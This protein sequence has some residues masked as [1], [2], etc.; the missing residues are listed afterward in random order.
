MEEHDGLIA[1]VDIARIHGRSSGNVRRSMRSLG[2]DLV[3]RKS[4]KPAKSRLYCRREEYEQVAGQLNPH[5][6][7][8]EQVSP[9]TGFFYLVQLEPEL[10]PDRFKLGFSIDTD[11]RLGQHRTAA[12]FAVIIKTWP[13]KAL[14][15]QTAIDCITQGCERLSPEVFRGDLTTVENFAD[16]FFEIMPHGV[17]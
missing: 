15:E 4:G 16:R 2:V 11:G 14:W 9:G 3:L 12:P 7:D 8:R 5:G 13:C 17:A 6:F 10:D 1:L